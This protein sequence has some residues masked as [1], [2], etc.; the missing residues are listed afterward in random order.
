MTRPTSEADAPLIRPLGRSEVA[1]L[2]LWAEDEGWNPG[3]DDAGPFHRADPEGFL[4]LFV[5]ARM[6]A[7]ISVVAAGPDFGFVGL[8]ICHPDFRGRGLG[9]KLWDAGLA[10]LGERTIGLDG[11]PA[12]QENYR[13]MGFAP[14]YRTWR[15]TGS[16]TGAARSESVAVGPADLDAVVACDHLHFPGPRRAF[17]EAWLAPPR[18]ARAIRRENAVVAYGAIRPCYAGFKIGPLF[19]ASEADARDLFGALCAEAG[20]AAV[21]IDVPEPATGFAWYLTGLGFS[22]GFDTMRMYRGTAPATPLAGVFGVTTLE[23]G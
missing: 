14:A 16:W 19:A 8:Y 5:G 20:G 1:D 22:R 13:R 11:V 12:Q 3:L 21:A 7:G 18:I 17:L 15:Y 9:R 6:A 4:G 23:L 2:L 10:R